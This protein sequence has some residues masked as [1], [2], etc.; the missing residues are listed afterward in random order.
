MLQ[1]ALGQAAR[2]VRHIPHGA[3]RSAKQDVADAH[4]QH[5]H[6]EGGQR[7]SRHKAV[8][9]GLHLSGGRRYARNSYDNAIADDGRGGVY[10]RHGA[11]GIRRSGIVHGVGGAAV[12]RAANFGAD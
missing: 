1:I 4:G 8:D 10:H 3:R 2:A 12:E 5:R 7:D 9:V 6:D 11:G